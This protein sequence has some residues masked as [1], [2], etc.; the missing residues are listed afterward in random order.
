MSAYE[1][2]STI[3]AVLGLIGGAVGFVRSV[4]AGR[5]A[6]EAAA[7]AADAQADA[8]VALQ[9]SAAADQRIAAALEAIARHQSTRPHP[10][11]GQRAAGQDAAGDL[12][13]ALRALVPS[14]DVL[15][16]IEPRSQNGTIRLRNVGAITA[17]AVSVAGAD[18]DGFPAPS[19]D[20]VAPG[21]ALILRVLPAGGR[22]EVTWHDAGSPN[23]RHETIAL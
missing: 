1:L 4:I 21:A 20:S 9:K 18:F 22:L 17:E 14:D 11:S 5:A 6:A 19:M 10:D 12:A 2:A 8:T 13:S 15:W 16:S 23:A 3:V 7:R